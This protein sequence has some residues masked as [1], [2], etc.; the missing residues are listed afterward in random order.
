MT[1][2][3]DQTVTIWRNQV[4][5]FFRSWEQDRRDG[6]CISTAEYE[7][8]SVDEIADQNAKM[9]WDEMHPVKPL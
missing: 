3:S 2:T 5:E 7:A 6:K 1:I 9:F 8:K 4:R